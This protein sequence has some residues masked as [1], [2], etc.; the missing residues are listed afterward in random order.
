[1]RVRFN[2]IENLREYLKGLLLDKHM[3]S[4]AV[5]PVFDVSVHQRNEVAGHVLGTIA[6]DFTAKEYF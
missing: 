1:M 5:K 4:R 3:W 2:D 6:G